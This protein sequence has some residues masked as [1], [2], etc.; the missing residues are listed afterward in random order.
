MSVNVS[1]DWCWSCN[2]KIEVLEGMIGIHGDW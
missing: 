1:S 2:H